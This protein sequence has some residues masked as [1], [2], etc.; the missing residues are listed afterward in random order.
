MKMV[1]VSGRGGFS[2]SVIVYG[3]GLLCE[4][5]QRGRIEQNFFGTSGK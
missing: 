3:Y 1:W 5:F 2:F 4:L